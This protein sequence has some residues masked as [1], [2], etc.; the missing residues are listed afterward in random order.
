[1]FLPYHLPFNYAVLPFVPH[2]DIKNR[3]LNPKFYKQI[4]TSNIIGKSG[5]IEIISK[6][7]ILSIIYN[8]EGNI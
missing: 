7:M 3:I 1:M 6:E 4:I 8:W 5:M 2:A